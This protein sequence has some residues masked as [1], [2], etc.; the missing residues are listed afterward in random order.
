MAKRRQSRY[1]PG[2]RS[3]SW[4]KVKNI[5]TQEVVVGGYTLGQGNR[6]GTVGALLLGIPGLDGLDYVGHVGTGFTGE[7]LADLLGRLAASERATSPFA[8]PLPRADAKDARWV[9]PVLVGEVAFS[10]FTA[11]GRLRHPTWRGLR[12]DKAPGDV[13]RE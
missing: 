7:V 6:A 2:R 11:T 8:A 3:S 13:V 1:E 5:R 9:E 10:E 12:E 4:V